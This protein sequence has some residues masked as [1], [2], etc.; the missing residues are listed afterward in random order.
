MQNV[1]IDGATRC[2]GEDQGYQPLY[3]KDVP[4]DDFPVMETEWTLNDKERALIA[5]GGTIRLRI[6]GHQHPPILAAVHPV[7]DQEPPQDNVESFPGVTR[8]KTPPSRILEEMSEVDF[9]DVI[10]IGNTTEGMFRFGSSDPDGGSILWMLE[11]T[12]KKLLELAEWK[13]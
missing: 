13:K 11:M 6:M 10:V 3:I 5:S 2:I 8:L 9:E 1:K 7:N 12:K 4:D